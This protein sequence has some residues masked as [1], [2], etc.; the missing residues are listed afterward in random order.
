MV[1]FLLIVDKPPF[2]DP[3]SLPSEVTF[4]LLLGINL[5]QPSVASCDKEPDVLGEDEPA[6]VD[7]TGS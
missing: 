7:I 2:E 6:A 4:I 5:T 1:S 3:Q